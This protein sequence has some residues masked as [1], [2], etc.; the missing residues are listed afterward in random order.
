MA[1]YE[2]RKDGGER[3]P[4]LEQRWLADWANTGLYRLP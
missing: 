1:K 2:K 4:P 3:E